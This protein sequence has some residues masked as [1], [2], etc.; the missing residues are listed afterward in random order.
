MGFWRGLDAWTAAGRAAVAVFLGLA[1]VVPVIWGL[2]RWLGGWWAASLLIAGSI[3]IVS[4]YVL[5][6]P[7]EGRPR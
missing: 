3:G 6:P 1:F 2:T 7:S 4:W 5:G